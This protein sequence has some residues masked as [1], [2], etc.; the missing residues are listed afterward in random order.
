MRKRS[1]QGANR[2][3]EDVAQRTLA[4][5]QA[6]STVPRQKG[7]EIRG[8]ALKNHSPLT[9]AARRA[10][11]RGPWTPPDF[12][13]SGAR[14]AQGARRREGWKPEGARRRRWLDATRESP[15]RR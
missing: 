4:A 7:G 6:W 15:T 13:A 11:K 9:N 14:S 12:L 8:G 2:T 3:G 1:P 5:G 10:P